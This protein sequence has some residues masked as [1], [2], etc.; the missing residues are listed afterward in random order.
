MENIPS[1]KNVKEAKT[2]CMGCS[3]QQI[4]RVDKCLQDYSASFFISL[5]LGETKSA[6]QYKTPLDP[7]LSAE[8]WTRPDHWTPQENSY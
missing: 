1:E 4:K 5:N 2:E 8:Q 7:E 6:N 3:P